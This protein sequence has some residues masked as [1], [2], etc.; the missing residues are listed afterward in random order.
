MKIKDEFDY[1]FKVVLNL[2]TVVFNHKQANANM[3][4]SMMFVKKL[5]VVDIVRG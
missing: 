3:L 1:V 2:I 5:E 4:H